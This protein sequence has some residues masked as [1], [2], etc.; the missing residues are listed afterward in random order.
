MKTYW[1][2]TEK[3]RSLL[4]E[5]EVTAT[6]DV[7]LMSRGVLKV[8]MPELRKIE[9]VKLDT[10]IYYEVNGIFFESAAKAQE[11]LALK[12]MC[13]S[14]DYYG[15][16]YDYQYA[17][18]L[19][20]KIEEKKLY[21][22]VDLQGLKLVLVKNKEAKDFNE[23]A[24]SEYEKAA[25]SMD[26]VLNGVWEDWYRCR[27][28]AAEHQ[29]VMDTKKEYLALTDGNEEMATTFLKKLYACDKI[30]EAIEWFSEGSPA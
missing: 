19:E 26:A 13:S 3:E 9:E 18:P 7:E 4:T 10:V 15:A 8:A 1:D 30:Q 21:R 22:Q 16:G 20:G 25:K 12:P 6:L 28:L 23:K 29:K 14:Y 11:M 5:A 24:K 17:K 27:E 2:Y